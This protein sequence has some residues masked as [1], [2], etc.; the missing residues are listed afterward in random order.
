MLDVCDIHVAYGRAKVLFGMSLSLS[1]GEILCMLGRNGAGKTTTLKAIAG[2]LPLI[3]GQIT[4][5]GNEVSNGA[6]R[7]GA[8]CG[9]GLIPQG[10]RLFADLTVA[11]NLEIGLMAS[12]GR[13]ELRERSLTLFPRLR[14]RL[15][16]SAWTLS[17]GEQQMLA[18]ARALCSGPQILLMD[19]PTEG[20]QPSMIEQIRQAMLQLKDDGIGILLVEQR[21]DAVLSVADRIQFIDQGR[22]GETLP[23]EAVRDDKERLI[24]YLG[25]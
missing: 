3:N 15:N 7:T 2:I 13:S 17:G 18:T 22:T 5:N 20:L 11:E 6:P 24:H 21:L 1:G 10:R 14:E 16:Q 8:R 25:V 12:G 9:I 4:M 23:V 19:E